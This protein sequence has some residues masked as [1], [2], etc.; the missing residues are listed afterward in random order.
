MP[1]TS[2]YLIDA[3]NKTLGRLATSIAQL[4]RS[5]NKITYLPYLEDN[6]YVIIINAKKIHVTGNKVHEKVYSTHSGKPGHL[7]QRRFIELQHSSPEKIIKTAVKG[8][9]PKNLLGK[10]LLKNLKVYEAGKHPHLA[11]KPKL[12]KI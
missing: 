5:K 10:R 8:M 11:Q 3:Q 6:N 4:L 1:K 2:W 9:L 12:L 7:K